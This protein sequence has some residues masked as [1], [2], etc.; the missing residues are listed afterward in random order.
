MHKRKDSVIVKA[1]DGKY[2]E[3][4]SSEDNPVT[5]EVPA[6]V[7][8]ASINLSDDIS[9]VINLCNPAW[10]S[11]NEDNYNLEFDDYDFDKWRKQ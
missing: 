7:P 9:I 1:S 2:H 6:N 5:I 8:S 11:D 3:F 10:H 4:I